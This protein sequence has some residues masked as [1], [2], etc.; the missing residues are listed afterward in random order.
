VGWATIE[1]MQVE[2]GRYRNDRLATYLVPTAL[3]A[4]R[5]TTRLL[6]E[7]CAT[8]PTGAKGLGELPMNPGAPA[9]IAA[10]AD[11]TGAWITDLP[12]TPER[13]LAALAGASKAGFEPVE[14]EPG[15]GGRTPQSDRL[16][17]GAG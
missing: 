9:V 3:D 8:S 4:P 5:I 7:P 13:V 16:L 12:A 10:I 11:A 14:H 1:E 15:S 2:A 6:D 17:V